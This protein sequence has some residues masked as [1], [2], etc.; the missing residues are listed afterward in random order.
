MVRRGM[1]AYPC[2]AHIGSCY[3]AWVI[4][5]SRGMVRTTP[6]PGDIFLML[7]RDADGSLTHRGHAGI[8]TRVGTTQIDTAEGN[9]GN[10]FALGL[11]DQSTIAAY[12]NPYGPD[13]QPTQWERGVLVGDSVAGASTR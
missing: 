3:R 9:C 7:Y 10:R 8:V 5:T 6:I 4:G 12:L 13:E 1:G 11:R 2:G